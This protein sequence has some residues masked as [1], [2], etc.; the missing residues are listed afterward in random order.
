MKVEYIREINKEK[1]ILHSEN[2]IFLM[3]VKQREV[4][5]NFNKK[6]YMKFKIELT[7]QNNSLI[8]P[9]E[10]NVIDFLKDE[11]F[12]SKKGFIYALYCFI[13]KAFWYS[14]FGLVSNSNAS[15]LNKFLQDNNIFD[16]QDLN[17]NE[18]RVNNECKTAYHFLVNECNFTESFL[19]VFPAILED[20]L[21]EY[22]N[23]YYF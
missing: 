15:N 12:L 19:A 18:E 13:G 9:F 23:D 3:S 2:K 21:I 1:C 5:L 16:N 8:F 10:A 14:K 11:Q 6:K 20:Y 22:Y 17:F 7:I 4:K